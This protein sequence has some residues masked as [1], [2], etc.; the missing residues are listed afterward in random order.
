MF[1]DAKRQCHRI[2]DISIVG[3]GYKIDF[4]LEG[5]EM[6]DKSNGS[7]ENKEFKS[8]DSNGKL[9]V[10]KKEKKWCELCSCDICILGSM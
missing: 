6:D 5:Y 7:E 2:T 8:P 9:S 10:E 3:S 4:K 1:K